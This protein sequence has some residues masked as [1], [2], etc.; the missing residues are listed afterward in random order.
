MIMAR[1]KVTKNPLSTILIVTSNQA[2]ALYFSQMRKDCRFSNMNV[3]CE[4]SA[5][6]LDDFINKTARRRNHGGFTVAWAVF[7]FADL[8]LKVSDVKEAMP[9]A[10]RKKVGL[11]WNNPNQS[12]WYLLHFQTPRGIVTDAKVFETA[13]GSL[14]PNFK[15]TPEYFLTDGLTLHLSL[16]PDKTKAANNASMYNMMAER[17]TG[18]SATNMIPLI[19]D[20]SRICGQADITHNQRQL[21]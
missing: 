9:L 14:I 13:L 19:N 2:N 3:Q 5:K 6:N 15:E 8:N 12:L 7:D 18:L 10:Q 16:F 17:E 4:A 11:A 20:I 21:K 1:K